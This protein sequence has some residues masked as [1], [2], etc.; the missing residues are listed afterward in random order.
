LKAKNVAK[1]Y[2]PH[3]EGLTVK[4]IMNFV[5]ENI[6]VKD[7]LPDGKELDKIPRSFIITTV[8]TIIGDSFM[9]W[10]KKI[11]KERN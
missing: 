9:D 3:Y 7:H 4:D 11:I 2:V 5:G 6:Q 8:A 1:V 10:V